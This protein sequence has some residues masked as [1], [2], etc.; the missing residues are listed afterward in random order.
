MEKRLIKQKSKIDLSK[1]KSIIVFEL[2]SIGGTLLITPL[3]RHLKKI[4]PRCK[5]T[6]VTIPKSYQILSNNPYIDEIIIYKKGIKSLITISKILLRN[7][8]VVLDYLCNVRSII[9]MLA[10]KAKYRIGMDTN[11]RN[12]FYTHIADRSGEP[13]VAAFNLRYL[14]AFDYQT[15][16]FALDL[17]FTEEDTKLIDDYLK[18]LNAS[19]K[20]I[21]ISPTG[22]WKTKIWME[23]KFA[24]LCDKIKD[25]YNAEII[26]LWGPGEE[27]I[28]QRI[29]HLS[30]H[31]VKIAPP[32]NLKQLAV[33]IKRLDLLIGND[34][35][36]K[37]IAVSQHT[38]TVTI[39]GATKP[40]AWEPSRNNKHLHLQKRLHCVPCD[41][42]KCPYNLECLRNITVDE[43]LKKVRYLLDVEYPE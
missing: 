42:T 26:I 8:D 25:H 10:S 22:T 17:F 28:A 9:V 5:L 32:T 41:K 23:H 30:C 3:F 43:V 38:P 33:L 13:Y 34:S 16:D 35:S 15:D 40:R 18:S 1:I 21:G 6:V 29:K 39:Y 4:L 37:H 27:E 20:L 7:Y 14:H 24:A 31:D 2:H 11:F 19:A 12:V 36:T